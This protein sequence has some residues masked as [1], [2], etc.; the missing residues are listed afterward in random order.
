MKLF[1]HS[2]HELT[3]EEAARNAEPRHGFVGFFVTLWEYLTELFYANFYTVLSFLPAMV[4]YVLGRILFQNVW[5]V[6][7]VTL[8]GSIPAGAGL[9]GMAAVAT[10]SLRNRGFAWKETYKKEW[11]ANLKKGA[12]P[13]ALY[14]VS[15]GL[16]SYMLAFAPQM[17]EVSGSLSVYVMLGVLAVLLQALLGYMTPMMTLVELP[18]RHYL[19]NSLLMLVACPKATIGMMLCSAVLLFGVVIL[20]LPY[21]GIYILMLG[22]AVTE[23]SKVAFVWPRLN[24]KLRIEEREREKHAAEEAQRLAEKAQRAEQEE[25]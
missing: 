8:L 7:L 14:I 20:F 10:E 6:L 1:N 9:C 18:P 22:I 19:K 12:L 17:S 4:L 11:K 2:Y 16:L 3:D 25:A 5:L 13:G 23:L 21:T 15:V 24:E